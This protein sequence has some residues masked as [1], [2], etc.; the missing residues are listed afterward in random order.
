[1]QSRWAAE[2]AAASR[3]PILELYAGVGH[4]GLAAARLSG[5]RLVQV[6]VDPV[7][8]AYAEENARVAGLADRTTIRCCDVET[9]LRLDEKYSVVIADPPYLTRH[10]VAMFPDDPILA[11]DGGDDGLIPARRCLAM[12]SRSAPQVPLL[13]QLRGRAQVDRLLSEK[14]D[15]LRATELRTVDAD[16][17]VVRLELAGRAAHT[18]PPASSPPAVS[19]AP[20][21]PDST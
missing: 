2:L 7:A 4:I 12:L 9:A 8:C 13:L 11:V 18:S 3:R 20:V 10:E 5:S 19:G 21:P 17:A 16:R 14:A 6:D 15:R 1:L